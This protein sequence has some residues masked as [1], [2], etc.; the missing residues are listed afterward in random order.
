MPGILSQQIRI[1][2]SNK[3]NDKAVCF[4]WL[5]Y[6]DSFLIQYH[7][8]ILQTRCVNNSFLKKIVL[9]KVSVSVTHCF[10]NLFPI[11]EV[12]KNFSFKN[13]NIEKMVYIKYIFNYIYMDIDVYI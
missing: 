5:V 8:L 11:S 10:S 4:E 1:P 13:V 7:T 6:L 12:R 2:R 3:S 9:Y